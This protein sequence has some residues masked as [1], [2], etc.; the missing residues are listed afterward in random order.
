MN[1]CLRSTMQ[2]LVSPSPAGAGSSRA[3][4]FAGSVICVAVLTLAH[5]AV[6]AGEI[7]TQVL[8]PKGHGAA[9]IVIIAEPDSRAAEPRTP[10][11]AVMDQ[12]NMQFVPE[13]LVIQTGSSVEF[14]NSDQ[15][16]HQVYSFSAAKSFQLSLYAG[17][18]Y[19]PVLFD[20]PGL[21][22]L[23]CNIHDQM[24]GYIYVT[25]SPFFGRTDSSGELRLQNL[26]AGHYTIKGWAPGLEGEDRRAGIQTQVNV[27][28]AGAVN[29][30]LRLTH[31]L[32]RSATPM[33]MDK[34]W[35][36]Y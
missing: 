13:V 25:D 32:R 29:A 14:P 20:R 35:V 24:I 28:A 12:H 31:A 17:R 8:D 22:T 6:L 3:R 11:T 18:H 26:P 1:E 4:A 34:R 2:R 7:D 10:R 21:V 16:L 23:G 5:S 19:P 27:A 30:L 36:D 9:G 33:S 15:I